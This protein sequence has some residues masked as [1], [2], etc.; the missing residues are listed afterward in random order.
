VENSVPLNNSSPLLTDAASRSRTCT[1]RTH[2][3]C[4]RSQ[5]THD[6]Y[7]ITFFSNKNSSVSFELARVATSNN[8]DATPCPS[9]VRRVAV[10]Q[11]SPGVYVKVVVLLCLGAATFPVSAKHKHRDIAVPLRP[12]AKCSPDELCPRYRLHIAATARTGSTV[13]VDFA[14]ALGNDT[15]RRGD[16]VFTIKEPMHDIDRTVRVK[17]M[18]KL[19]KIHAMLR[20]MY[21]CNC[22]SEL[23]PLRA[24]KTFQGQFLQWFGRPCKGASDYN[25]VCSGNY[26]LVIKTICP[27]GDTTVPELAPPDWGHV[28]LVRTPCLFHICGG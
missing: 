13:L 22:T 12:F 2:Y 23:L 21:H 14:S 27:L 8:D 1:A 4:N 6:S 10:M 19:Q 20:C 25:A 24:L 16:N 9:A 28:V 5:S 3:E 7:Q 11:I 17:G 18:S 15:G 26:D